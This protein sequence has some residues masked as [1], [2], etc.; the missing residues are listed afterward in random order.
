[1]ERVQPILVEK[2]KMRQGKYFRDR[3]S[4][5]VLIGTIGINVI[6]KCDIFCKLMESIQYVM[7]TFGVN[8]Y[9]CDHGDVQD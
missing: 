6:L 4:T 2:S 7:Q 5:N 8:I 3:E 9:M 1:M